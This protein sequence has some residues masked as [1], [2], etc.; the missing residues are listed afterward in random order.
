MKFGYA[1]ISTAEQNFDLQT[2]ALI[3]AGVKEKNIFY[4]T[5]SG[6]RAERK[7]LDVLLSVLR[8]GDVLFVWKLDRIARNVKHLSNLMNYFNSDK[9]HFK[10]IKEPFIDTSSSHGMFI[11][12]IFSALSQ[13]ERDLISERTHAGLDS[14]R[15]R[16]KILGK[17]KGLSKKAQVTAKIC[18]A[19]YKEGK[20]S[21][22][23]MLEITNVSK[24]T[25]YNYLRYQGVEIGK[26][27]TV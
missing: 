27:Y 10:S 3:K 25:F 12:N 19:L 18:E 13:F 11:F 22:K 26:N 21:V 23:Q 7:S 8:S 4:D 2:D 17:P 5:S 14:A 9:I 16:G 24:R 20:L 1:R 15:K 6:T